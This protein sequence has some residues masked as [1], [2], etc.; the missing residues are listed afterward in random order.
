[1]AVGVGLIGVLGAVFL[2]Y[3]G[4]V[5]ETE[6][7]FFGK[8]YHID[9]LGWPHAIEEGAEGPHGSSTDGTGPDKSE[10]HEST[11]D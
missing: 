11:V 6:Q 10:A 7:T 8:R 2:G 3:L 5:S 4:H 1:M 9:L